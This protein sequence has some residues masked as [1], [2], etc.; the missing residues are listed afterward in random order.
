MKKGYWIVRA[1]I[2]DMPAYQA[3]VAAD[4]PAIDKYHGKFLV[5][6]GAIDVK[7]G[8][9]RSRQVVIEFPDLATAQACYASPE[10]QHAKTFRQGAAEF[11]L[12]IVEGM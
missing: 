9:A 3:Y 12:V 8:G 10:Y 4:G 11:D 6:G 1:D 7:E 5:R 2:T